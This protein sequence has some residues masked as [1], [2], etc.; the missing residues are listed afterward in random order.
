MATQD[1][2]ASAHF[3][4]SKL[5]L[6]GIAGFIIWGLALLVVADPSDRV[7]MPT[8]QYS[9]HLKKLEEEILTR[10][11]PLLAINNRTLE[12]FWITERDLER[13]LVRIEY[14]N[15][16]APSSAWHP[17]D[18]AARSVFAVFSKAE[19]IHQLKV[20]EGMLTRREETFGPPN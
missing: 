18:L 7:K 14:P 5:T 11:L 4:V 20:H 6:L 17:V 16:I 3:T 12:F 2:P 8:A 9:E 10:D 19:I 15:E 1:F 13:R